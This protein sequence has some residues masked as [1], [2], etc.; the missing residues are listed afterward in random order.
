MGLK[1]LTHF[2]LMFPFYTRWKHQRNVFLVFSGGIKRKYWPE[3]GWIITFTLCSKIQQSLK[4]FH[5][6]KLQTSNKSRM[7][8]HSLSQ[9]FF[10]VVTNVAGGDSFIRMCSISF[11]LSLNKS[12]SSIY[13]H[14]ASGT[15]SKIDKLH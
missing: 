1:R 12:N 6:I 11:R 15:W 5:K 3:M 14:K 13:L 9:S 10:T 4:L 2:W 7:A 8:C